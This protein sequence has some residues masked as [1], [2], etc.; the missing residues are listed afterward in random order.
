MK[1]F[2]DT[3]KAGNARGRL[4]AIRLIPFLHIAKRQGPMK[5]LPYNQNI[6]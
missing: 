2:S 4:L 3:R 5:Q 1:Q 6:R